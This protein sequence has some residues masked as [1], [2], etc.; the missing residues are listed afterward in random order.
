MTRETTEERR[1][2]YYR[3]HEKEREARKR[4]YEKNKAKYFGYVKKYKAKYP[5]K[6]RAKKMV[7]NALRDG[8]LERGAC[9]VCGQKKT[10][11]HHPDYSKP[12]EVIWLCVK[13]HRER[14][15]LTALQ[16]L[17]DKK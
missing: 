14:H 1:E 10:E 13:H 7:S 2:R 4:Y 9:V 11:G 17:I 16:A 6:E 3:N 15:S 8:K 5:D 12:L